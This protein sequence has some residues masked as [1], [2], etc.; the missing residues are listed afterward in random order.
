MKYIYSASLLFLSLLMFGQSR[1]LLWDISPDESIRWNVEK[2]QAH[3]DHIEMSG[4]NVSAILTYGVD[5]SGQ[6]INTKS[7]IFPM[8][9]TVPNNTHASLHQ[10]FDGEEQPIIHV[11]GVRVKEFPVTFNLKGILNIASRTNTGISIER[12][13]FP[14][15]DKTACIERIIIQNTTRESCNVS[16]NFTPATIRTPA[17]KGVYGE[18]IISVNLTHQG[19][20]RLLPAET[21]ELGLI[22]SGRKTCD[23]PYNFSPGYELGKRE[24]FIRELFE[25]LILDTPNDTLD[26]AFAFAKIRAAES[27][28]D[29]KGGLMHGPG[30]GAYYAAIWAN[31]Q[32]EYVNPFFPFLGN[33]EGNE[34]AI[35]SFR[36][37]ARYMN[38]DFKP[39]PSSIIAEGVDFWNGA[40]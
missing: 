23:Q 22:Y 38:P 34:S 36:H 4:L 35:N 33:L 25:S 31:D 29:T 15:R 39:I 10:D 13:I 6:L 28:Y 1:H 30:G 21:I 17:E 3:S 24:K 26:Q 40:G 2:A 18:Y 7:L 27:I 5:E 16:V 37:F 11:D 14:S 19:S 20:F 32:A 8:L 12:S 9:R